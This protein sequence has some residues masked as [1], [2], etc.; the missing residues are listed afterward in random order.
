M[1]S[2]LK[3]AKLPL[4]L[5]DRVFLTGYS[6]RLHDRLTGFHSP[7]YVFQPGQIAFIH[8][9]K[10]AGTAAHRM[11]A[12]DPRGRFINLDMHRPVS[13]H[14]PPQKF[15]YLTILRD[16]AARVWSYFHMVLQS[17][18]KYPYHR[19][20]SKGLEVF[21]ERCWEARNMAC[22]YYSG[23]MAEPDAEVLRLAGQNLANF[24]KVILFDD[25]A[26]QFQAYLSTKGIDAPRIPHA[27]KSS[28]PKP[29]PAETSLILQYNR[30]DQE[31][32]QNWLNQA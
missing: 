18:P 30:L 32:Y 3:L 2:A 14:C 25:F 29:G 17:G 21:L 12:T 22:R 11:L 6:F 23:Y 7:D 4:K 20:A 1:Q 15:S 19:M 27:R 8:V 28:Y 9:P 10:C 31:L 24:E 16:P 26:A 13:L 5:L